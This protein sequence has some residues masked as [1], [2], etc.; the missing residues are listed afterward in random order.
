MGETTLTL[1]LATKSEDFYVRMLG[2][3]MSLA[4][5]LINAPQ[6]EE[7]YQLPCGES[8]NAFHVHYTTGAVTLRG[9]V[10][11]LRRR[12]AG[13]NL[14]RHTDRGR[15]PRSSQGWSRVVARGRC[16]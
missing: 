13:S 6:R 4:R 10:C 2:D 11:L 15:V 1:T 12:F 7:T 3:T 8:C 16:G 9:C 5:G 14:H